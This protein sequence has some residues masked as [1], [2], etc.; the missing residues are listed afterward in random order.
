MARLKLGIVFGGSCEEHPISVKSAHE[1]AQSLDDEKYE[2][3][4]IG[5]TND[6]AWRLCDGPDPNWENG[7]SRPA[8][9]SPD[10]SAP[11]LLVLDQG[12]YETIGLDLVL[13]VLHGKLGEDGAIQG[14]LELSGI[15]Y[16]GLRRPELRAVH[17][18]V[19]GLRRRG[20]AGIAT[21]SF[22][23]VAARRARSIPTGSPIPSSSSRLAPARRSAS[24]RSTREEE[25]AS[26]VRDRTAVRL[27]G[28]DRGGRRRQ[29]GRLRDPGRAVRIWWPARSTGSPCPTGSSRSTRRAHPEAGSENSTFIVPADISARGTRARPGD[30]EDPLPRPGVQRTGPGRPVPHGGRDRGA[31]R[32]EHAARPDL[33]Q[34]LPADDGGRR[35]AARRGD[36]PDGVARRCTG[37]KR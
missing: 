15:P 2:P 11:G 24:P 14:L 27:E 9:L 28:A 26:A 8:V 33:L 16:V 21:P 20:S 29:R 17:G 25:L 32:G 22:W 10:R 37:K 35:T 4:W 30:G 34:P 23:T 1:V 19:P 12:R 18:Q 6:G 3:F 13:P 31:Q 5:I 7:S 36:R